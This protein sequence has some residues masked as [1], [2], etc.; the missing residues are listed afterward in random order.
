M[1]RPVIF[2]AYRRG[3][4]LTSAL[5]GFLQAHRLII[6]DTQ[7]GRPKRG[8]NVSDITMVAHEALTGSV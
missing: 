8:D 2:R 7:H 6:F 4:L 3:R 1:T 5:T